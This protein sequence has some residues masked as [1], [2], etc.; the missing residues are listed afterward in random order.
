[1]A[2]RKYEE[3][4]S[5]KPKHTRF[6]EDIKS[7]VIELLEEDYSPE[8]I[9]GC[10]KKLGKPTVSHETIYQHVWDDKKRGG[11]LYTLLIH[12]GK[13]YRKQGARKIQEE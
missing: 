5:I 9:K 10:L 2:Q 6:T 8:Q 13:R 4:L 7:D 1:L 11:K 12:Q 3:R